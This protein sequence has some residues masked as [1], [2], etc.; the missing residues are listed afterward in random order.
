M[1]NNNTSLINNLGGNAGFG[2]N[3]LDRND[4]DSTELIDITPIFEDGLNFFGT[5]Y[6]GFYIN[7]NGNITFNESLSDFTP[8]AITGDTKGISSLYFR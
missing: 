2:E 7:N 1:D 3:F 5:T 4:D 6:Q 8:F